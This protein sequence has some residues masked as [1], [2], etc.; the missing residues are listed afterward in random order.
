MTWDETQSTGDNITAA[1]WNTMNS[2]MR[3]V[4]TTKTGAYSAVNRD[5]IL[6]NGTFSVT[7]PASPSANDIFDVKN[8]G[9][10]TITVARNGNNID[11]T[12]SDITLYQNESICIVSD[13]SNYFLI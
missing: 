10:G 2:E 4:V 9:T 7:L 5:I 13:G 8:I 12:A 3:G 11:G 1:E 6:A